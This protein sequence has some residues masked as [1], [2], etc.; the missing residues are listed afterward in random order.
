[1]SQFLAPYFDSIPLGYSILQMQNALVG[2]LTTN[3]W[4]L[5][6]QSDGNWSDVI[7]PATETIGTSK[8]REVTRIYFPDNVTIKIG[9]YQECISDALPQ[10]FQLT[11]LNGGAVADAVTIGGVTVTGATGGAGATANDNLRALYYALRDS[12][13]ATITGWS[14]WYNGTNTLVATKKTV[15]AAVTI[16]S[17]ANVTYAALDA[18]V[19]SGAR[20]SYAK[21]DV[22]L[23]FGITT[24]L[25]NGFVYYMDVWSRSFTIGTKCL[26]GVTGQI[27]ASYVDHAE[28]LAV[29]PENA[30]DLC[31]PIELI[32]GN[33]SDGAG[34]AKGRPTHWWILPT[35]YGTQTVPNTDATY[36]YS[37][38]EAYGDAHS[39]TGGMIP[40]RVSDGGVSYKSGVGYCYG[41]ALTF[42]G[43]LERDDINTIPVMPTLGVAQFKT[44]PMSV[45]AKVMSSSSYYSQS[46]RFIPAINLPVL[47]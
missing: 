26:S 28:A 10:S 7:P 5:L 30:G 40:R 15:T 8:F 47:D 21:V 16:S 19:L 33:L 36:I 27:F 37:V 4:Q 23:G 13:D 34:T 20:S 1:M 24:D 14:F 25:T 45:P 39:F 31:T 9:S 6:A 17:N 46:I 11:A 18:P 42:S 32:V 38:G 35:S 3:G 2:N 41:D 12:V 22:S 44:A 43:L 29:M